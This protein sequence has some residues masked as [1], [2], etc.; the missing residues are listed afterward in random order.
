MSENVVI[1]AGLIA[2]FLLGIVASFLYD[3][4][5]E[6]LGLQEP[7]TPKTIAIVLTLTVLCLGVIIASQF[8]Q[9]D[10]NPK[11][12]SR[13]IK[14]DTDWPGGKCGGEIPGTG[15]LPEGMTP[16]GSPDGE[17]ELLNTGLPA[18]GRLPGGF[19]KDQPGFNTRMRVEN[20]LERR[21][22]IEVSNTMNVTV[23]P[24][25]VPS[26][27]DG[28]ILIGNCGGGA[29]I[30]EFEPVPLH[31]SSIP[32]EVIT[33]AVDSDYFKL[34]PGELDYFDF[35][36]RC[37]RPGMYQIAITITYT[38]LEEHNDITFSSPLLYVCPENATFWLWEIG[39]DSLT[40]DDY[41]YTVKWDSENQ[42]YYSED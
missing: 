23:L 10:I 29:Q 13:L 36:F 3:V 21:D 41:L 9:E 17:V 1:I 15:M 42:Y 30:H 28:Y 34:E 38:Y 26:H 7:L 35:E 18:T 33:A 2:T 24:S 20:I 32:Y 6:R 39:D 31:Q 27:I 11:D 22:W 8:Y 16:K 25:S 37:G 14:V 5:K 12:W 19:G 4:L 40:S